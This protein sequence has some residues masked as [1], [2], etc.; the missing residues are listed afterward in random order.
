MQ[1]LHISGYPEQ[2]LQADH[3]ITPGAFYLGKP[4]LPQQLVGKVRLFWAR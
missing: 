2:H 3:N 1:V 4:F